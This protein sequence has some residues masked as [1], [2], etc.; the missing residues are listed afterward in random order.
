MAPVLFERHRVLATI[1]VMVLFAVGITASI[2]HSSAL[3]EAEEAAKH[4]AASREAAQLAADFQSH[5]AQIIADIRADLA[6]GRTEEANRLLDKYRP[7][8][9]GSLDGLRP[10]TGGQ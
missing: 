8:A 3:D 9:N 4:Q 2:L 10:K 6:A 7:V 5:K 1:V